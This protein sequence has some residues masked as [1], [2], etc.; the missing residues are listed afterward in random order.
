MSNNNTKKSI[1]D[2]IKPKKKYVYP[3]HCVLCK[4]AEVDPRT[5]EKHTRDNIFWRSDDDDSRRNQMNAIAGR[6]QNKPNI[7]LSVEK[8]LA[9]ASSI[10]KQIGRAHV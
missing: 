6:K 2:L 3:C 9:G 7:I 10:K 4:G 8:N 5:Q 1:A